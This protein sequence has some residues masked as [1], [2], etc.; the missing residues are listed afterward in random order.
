ML[1]PYE[2]QKKQSLGCSPWR[3]NASLATS[4]IFMKAQERG[5]IEIAEK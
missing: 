3:I 5:E 1:I 4:L 2:R